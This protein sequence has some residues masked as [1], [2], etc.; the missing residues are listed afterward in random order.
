VHCSSHAQP[1]NK[2]AKQNPNV[3][4]EVFSNVFLFS[5]TIIQRLNVQCYWRMRI[6]SAMAL[7]DNFAGAHPRVVFDFGPIAVNCERV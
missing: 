7:A 2:T 4:G 1:Q 3:A 5:A 6:L